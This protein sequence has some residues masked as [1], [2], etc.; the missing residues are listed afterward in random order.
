[1]LDILRRR[2]HVSKYICLALYMGLLAGAHCDKVM[3]DGENETVRY[4]NKM[5]M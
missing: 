1:M 5:V 2:T 4:S 3:S